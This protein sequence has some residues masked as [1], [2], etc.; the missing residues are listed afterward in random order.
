MG[1][2]D[3]F[4][5]QAQNAASGGKTV[6]I[7]AAASVTGSG[8]SGLSAKV[9]LTFSPFI[10][11]HPPFPLPP[12]FSGWIGKTHGDN[13]FRQFIMLARLNIYVPSI[14]GDYWFLVQGSNMGPP[15]NMS[16]ISDSVPGSESGFSAPQ[17]NELK[18]VQT[19]Q[20]ITFTF[21]IS[22]A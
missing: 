8:L 15:I 9:D 5:Q 13:D 19:A 20:G 16:G 6:V 14:P 17:G 11:K 7:K 4:F 21:T 2:L 18:F 22:I 12:H 10:P 1:I 3:N